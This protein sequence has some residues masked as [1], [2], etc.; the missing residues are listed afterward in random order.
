LKSEK[1]IFQFIFAHLLIGLIGF[2]FPPIIYIYPLIVL[3]YGIKTVYASKNSNNE[4]LFFAAYFVGM[5][6]F[7]RMTKCIFFYE[8]GKWGVLFFMVLGLSYKRFKSNA[9]I[10]IFILFLYL[11]GLAVAFPRFEEGFDVFNQITFNLLGSV[12][13]I[14]TA[15]YCFNREIFFLDF[16]KVLLSVMY[17]LF[18]IL[19]YIILYTPKT[20]TFFTTEANSGTSGGYGPNQVATVLGLGGL[21][22][23]SLFLFF[24]KNF[25]QKTFY[26]S[27]SLFFLYRSLITFSRG[28]TYTGLA[29]IIILLLYA[30]SKIGITGKFKIQILVIFLLIF[31]TSVF[32]YS[33]YQTDGLILKRYTGKTFNG[34]EK[35]DKF[36][37]RKEIA[38]SEFQIFMKYPI[39]GSG[40][41]TNTLAKEEIS[42][43]SIT[44]HN[45]IT[46]LIAE[47]GLFGV[48]IFLFLFFTPLTYLLMNKEQLFLLPFFFFW[49][50]TINHSAMRIAAPAFIYGLSLLKINFNE[51][52]TLPRQ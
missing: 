44:S 33:V 17:P 52:P 45:E 12:A 30:Y 6:C 9:T 3:L 31:G 24:S 15:L 29:C 25:F 4:A 20:G 5:E 42:A 49:L 14:S 8:T 16:K 51:I 39:F 1:K 36:S 32:S 40:I 34:E 37:G 21:I 7:L 11:P 28:G 47:Q 19:V 35:E 46:R 27:L 10:F 41:G 23:F 43:K 38:E 22:L 50:L 48:L 13:L 26:L 18:S 2:L